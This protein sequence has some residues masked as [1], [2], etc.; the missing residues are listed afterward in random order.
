MRCNVGFGFWQMAYGSKAD[1]T[2]DNYVAART[3]MMEFEGDGGKKLN[4]KPNLSSGAPVT[5]RER[6]SRSSRL[7]CTG[8]RTEQRLLQY[9]GRADDQLSE[10]IACTSPRTTSKTR[11]GADD[12]AVLV[13]DAKDQAA[14]ISEAIADACGEIDGYV[15][16]RYAL[17]LPKPTLRRASSGW[18]WI[19]S[20]TV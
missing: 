17:P 19:L 12:Y 14:R 2:M 20:S 7:N 3:A 6:R 1:L 15:Q 18:R 5:G 9:G 16:Q 8:Q 10:L 4:I 11:L 13:G